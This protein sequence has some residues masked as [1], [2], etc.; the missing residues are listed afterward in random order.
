MF[1]THALDILHKKALKPWM[2]EFPN[3]TGNVMIV[4]FAIGFGSSVTQ[5][6]YPNNTLL[7]KSRLMFCLFFGPKQPQK[8]A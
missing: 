1:V 7:G 5:N 3:A 2:V 8:K 6:I 4:L